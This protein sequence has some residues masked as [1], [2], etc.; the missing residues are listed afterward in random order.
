MAKIITKES[1]PGPGI[2][3]NEPEKRR[4]F[5]FFELLGAKIGKLFQLNFIYTIAIIPLF[6]G[7]YFSISLNRD[8]KSLAD[9][10]KMPIFTINP[11]YI[12]LIIL[13]VSVFITGP[14]TAG[15]VFVL[16]NLQRREHAWIWS[17]F[18]AQFKKNYLQ[19]VAMAAIDIVVYTLL[20]VAFN[21]YMYIMPADM[22]AAGTMMPKIAA[23]LIGAVT[24]IFTWAHYY[25]YTMMVTFKLKLNKIIKNSI[26]FA[27]GKL[28]HNILITAI[29]AAIM[30]GCLYLFLLSPMAL[31]LIVACILFS[32]MG[33]VIV[34]VTYPT[35][36]SN[37]IQR[38]NKQT[39]VLNT[40]DV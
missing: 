25:I 31:A 1:K 26:I 10:A 3:K 14:A 28:W 39:R 24:I 18:W 40:R 27:L 8:L 13:A 20:Y 37:M 17:D 15:S 4:F 7:L 16:R 5:L 30:L 19:G 33:F 32:F 9:L 34:F 36:D 12:S 11:D 23:G 29:L 22:P 6:I 21:F 2:S 35:I 38:A